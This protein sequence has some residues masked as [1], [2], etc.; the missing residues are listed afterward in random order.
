MK[1]ETVREGSRRKIG[2]KNILKD[3]PLSEKSK[4]IYLILRNKRSKSKLK[5]SHSVRI[6]PFRCTLYLIVVISA[7]YL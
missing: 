7:R 3:I 5:P 6:V 2:E 1:K 4:K